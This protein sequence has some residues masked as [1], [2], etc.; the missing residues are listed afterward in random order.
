MGAVP[1]AAGSRLIGRLNETKALAGVL[2]QAALGHPG[3]MVIHGEA[4]V[5]KTRLVKEVCARVLGEGYE[6]LWGSCVHFGAA[7]LSYAPM[8]SALDRWASQADRMVAA[9]VFADAE[10]LTALLPSMGVRA[11]AEVPGTVLSWIDTVLLRLARRA[12]TVVVVDDLQWADAA[13]LDALA[14]LITGFGVQRLAV[15]VTIR[16]EARP[17]GSPLHTWL[18]DVRRLPSVSELTL[19]RLDAQE[20]AE[21]IASLL[22][23]PASEE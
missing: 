17:E 8:I 2:E 12:P 20:T 18:A 5:G 3:A 7:S 15:I 23:S 21:Q 16:L 22:R 9:E 13:S 14:Y 11:S 10:E 19:E 4:G 1:D 6:V